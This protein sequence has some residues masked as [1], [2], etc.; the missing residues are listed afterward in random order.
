MFYRG[1]LSWWSVVLLL[2]VTALCQNQ[3]AQRDPQAIALLR[4]AVT[5]AGGLTA[6][7]GLKDFTASGHATLYRDQALDGTVTLTGLASTFELISISRAELKA[8][9]SSIARA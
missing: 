7:T 5:A 1:L 2:S 9:S 3:R 4:Q 6:L 8:G